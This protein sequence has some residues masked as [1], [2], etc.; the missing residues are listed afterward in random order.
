MR[1]WLGLNR[2]FGA[3]RPATS[4]GP[5]DHVVILD[6]TMS[7]LEAGLETN[8]GQTYKLLC[9]LAPNRH[10]SLWY[11]A[12]IPWDGWRN[13]VNVIAGRG[14]NRRIRRAY[15]F[16]A[17]RYRP[18]DRIFLLG[19]SRGAYA[20]RS[21][22]GMIDQIGLLK[23]KHATERNIR[24]IF[25]HY[26]ATPGGESAQAFA[27]LY[28]HETA[29]IEMIGVWDT[30]KALG[31][32]LP[33]LWRISP[34]ATEFHSHRLGPTIRHGYHALAIDERRVAYTPVLW[35][36]P[37]NWDGMAEQMWFRGTHGDVGGHLC[38]FEP[39]RPLANIPLVWMLEK[40]EGCNLKLPEGWRD[41]FPCDVNAP[42]LGFWRGFGILFL[43]RRKRVIGI[44][45]SERIHPTVA[46]LRKK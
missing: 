27:R 4:R 43:W 42:S 20:A 9:E 32:R 39:A 28:C 1:D 36:T 10:V 13:A 34:M 7:T 14:I 44:D 38:G 16:I 8:A 3:S 15:G 26:Q 22:A 21:L 24:E 29:E 19:Y 11:E 23:A 30:V 25:R 18:G 37:E 41:R 35:E 40:L 17:S 31:I 46:E 12:G 6:G 5:I 45:R 2:W 33:I